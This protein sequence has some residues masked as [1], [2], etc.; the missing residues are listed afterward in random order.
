MLKKVGRADILGALQLWFGTIL[1]CCCHPV[2]CA[3]RLVVEA[4]YGSDQVVIDAAEP[5]SCPQSCMP[6][7]VKRLLE[8]HEDMLKACWCCRHFSQSILRLKIGSVVLLPA[9]KP[10]CSF[11]MISSAC[12]FSLFRMILSMTSLGRLIR[13]MVR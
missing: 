2:D 4:F 10:A 13:L 12:G 8:V 6:N 3:G 9:L 1:L 5:H 11:L 7:Y